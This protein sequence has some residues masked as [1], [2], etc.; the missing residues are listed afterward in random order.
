MGVMVGDGEGV[1][2][3]VAVGLRVGASVGSGPV[4]VVT[5]LAGAQAAIRTQRMKMIARTA[6]L[7]DM[8]GMITQGDRY[9]NT[10]RPWRFA[11]AYERNVGGSSVRLS[12][13]NRWAVERLRAGQPNR[14]LVYFIRSLTT[15]RQQ[16]DQWI[17]IILAEARWRS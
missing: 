4:G 9:G 17:E 16:E 3:D 11:A 2:V 5:G 15:A 12:P 7:W 8:A 6:G 1:G 14:S 13:W 10:S